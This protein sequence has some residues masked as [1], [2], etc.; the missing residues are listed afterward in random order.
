[1]LFQI[2]RK[3]LTKSQYPY[4]RWFENLTDNRT[5]QDAAIGWFWSI[6]E[7]MRLE[8]LSK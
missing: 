8:C 3:A 1:M 2:N 7:I 6:F 4:I 5:I